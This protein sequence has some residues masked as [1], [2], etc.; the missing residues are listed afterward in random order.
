MYIYNLNYYFK[1]NYVLL[2]NCINICYMYT[3]KSMST[4]MFSINTL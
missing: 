2:T 1:I 4:L 3:K